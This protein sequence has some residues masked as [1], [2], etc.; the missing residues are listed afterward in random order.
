MARSW[1]LETEAAIS[2]ATTTPAGTGTRK[3]FSSS[4]STA[5]RALCAVNERIEVGMMIAS[6]VPTETCM[7][8]L[9]S[10][11]RAVRNW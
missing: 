7:R 2:E 11:P 3:D 10:T 9:S 4:M 6:D 8:T 5:P 1:P